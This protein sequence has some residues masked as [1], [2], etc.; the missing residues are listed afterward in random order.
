MWRIRCLIVLIAACSA[1]AD[2]AK[3]AFESLYG[4]RVRRALSTPEKTDDA[5][6]AGE[7]LAAAKTMTETPALLELLCDGV[8]QLGSTHAEGYP[9]AAEA[10]ELLEQH[11]KGDP[12]PAQ[13]KLLHIRTLLTRQGGAADRAAASERLVTDLARI[14]DLRAVSERY[15][16]AAALYRRAMTL[17]G[18]QRLSAAG[19][20]RDRLTWV[21]ARQ[22]LLKQ[23]DLLRTRLLENANDEATA[24]QL[25]LLEVRDFD[26]PAGA[27]RYLPHL[28][29]EKLAG[30][31]ERAAQTEDNLKPQDHLDLA[32]WYRQLAE[33]TRDA[34][35]K[36]AMWRRGVS[37]Y[38]AFLLDPTTGGLAQAKT[39]LSLQNA[40]SALE[41]LG[42]E[43]NPFAELKLA[44]PA[45]APKRPTGNDK[46]IDVLAMIDVEKD[47]VTG[48]WKKTK[49]GIRS[50]RGR[51]ERVT[52]PIKPLGGY[53]LKVKFTCQEGIHYD[54]H[55]PVGSMSVRLLFGNGS[56]DNERWHIS[57][58]RSINRRDYVNNETTT[59]RR[60]TAG[61]SHECL[62][63]V[64][65]KEEKDAKI[66]VDIDGK[67]LIRWQGPQSHLYYNYAEM[68]GWSMPEPA[69]LGLGA[70]W[71]TVDFEEIKLR[72]LDGKAQP[73]RGAK[74]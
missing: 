15:D 69:A 59:T 71:A 17:A 47:K 21:T 36:R 35:V 3:D 50:P 23:K 53:Q 22:Q 18:Q 52:I 57:G 42:P 27:V 8:Y 62:I 70:F 14:G 48:D 54:I 72:M 34:T 51:M 20:I 74:P 29:D 16:D 12:A 46:W 24:R 28:K 43:T 37:H 25:V 56:S 11:G 49:D 40:E 32:E 9:F 68:D 45:D 65:F 19:A 64:Q 73:L 67:P 63:A 39:K 2:G 60:I 41:R 66:E 13:E 5:T 26:Q 10:M 4:A 58:L 6:L 61:Q 7:L 33:E 1:A 44:G 38:Q 31:V 30:L 55:L